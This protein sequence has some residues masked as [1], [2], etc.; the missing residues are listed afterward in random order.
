MKIKELIKIM[1]DLDMN[2]REMAETLGVT[3]QAVGHWIAGRRDIPEMA[4]RLIRMFH[5]DSD[6][7]EYFKEFA[8][9]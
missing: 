7:V 4:A 1:S 6:D 8:S 2:M 5:K 9:E 3:P